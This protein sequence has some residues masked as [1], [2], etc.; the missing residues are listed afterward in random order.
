MLFSK[1]TFSSFLF[2]PLRTKIVIDLN[3]FLIFKAS[4]ILATKNL[5]HLTLTNVSTILFSPPRP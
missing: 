4:T 3:F 2:S 1:N 5:L